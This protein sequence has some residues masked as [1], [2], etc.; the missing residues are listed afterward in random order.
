MKITKVKLN[1]KT[2]V[3][4]RDNNEGYLLQGEQAIKQQQITALIVQKRAN[5]EASI[6][7]KTLVRET[8]FKNK[9]K[10]DEKT[11]QH[12][13]QKKANLKIL[14]QLFEHTLNP[15]KVNAPDNL[16]LLKKLS[17]KDL[18][19]YLAHKFSED[20]PLLY[21]QKKQS[22]NLLN[23]LYTCLQ[24]DKKQITSY[25]DWAN[26]FIG[27][28]Q[29]FLSKSIINNT[30]KT[31]NTAT[32][33][34]RLQVLDKL[35]EQMV[36]NHRLE[37]APLY[38]E[39][40]PV[41]KQWRICLDTT[42]KYTQQDIDNLTLKDKYKSV[43]YPK[44]FFEFKRALKNVLTV[45]Q[46]QLYKAGKFA[47]LLLEQYSLELTKYL[48][49]YF[50]LKKSARQLTLEDINYYLTAETI[51]QTIAQQLQNAAM[52]HLLQRGKLISYQLDQKPQIT[53]QDLQRIKIEEAF[54]MQFISA[55]AFAASN[56][57]NVIDPSVKDDI[58]TQTEFIKTLAQ[59]LVDPKQKNEGIHRL[60]Q[61]L[62]SQTFNFD[63]QSIDTNHQAIIKKLQDK[64]QY[65]SAV[66]TIR[67]AI[68]AIRNQVI[69]FRHNALKQLFSMER[70][71][72]I[73][74]NQAGK[75]TATNDS[76]FSQVELLVDLFKNELTNLNYIFTEKIRTSGILDFYETTEIIKHF[77][78]ISLNPKPLAFVPGF[79][80]VFNWG[81][82][83]QTEQKDYLKLTHYFQRAYSQSAKN[84]VFDKKDQAQYNLLGLIYDYKFTQTFLDDH[85]A[86]KQAVAEVLAA[87]KQRAEEKLSKA[88]KQ[89]QGFKAIAPY[90]VWQTPEDYLKELQSEL[91]NDENKKREE[92]KL[93]ADQTGHYQQFI[94]QLFVKGFDNFLNTHSEL[95]FYKTP[96]YQFDDITKQQSAKEQH[97]QVE[98][99]KN[100]LTIIHQIDTNHNNHIA[101]WLFCKMLDANYLNQLHNQFSKWQQA[102]QA[103]AT[104]LNTDIAAFQQ[105]ISLSLL[106]SDITPAGYQS[107]YK[108]KVDYFEELQPFT[109]LNKD[110][111]TKKTDLFIQPDGETPIIYG[112]IE[113]AKKYATREV[114]TKLLEQNK[115]FKISAKDIDDWD[116]L[117]KESHPQNPAKLSNIRQQLHSAWVKAAHKT[118]YKNN[119]SD[120]QQTLGWLNSPCQHTSGLT[121]GAYYQELCNKLAE[122]NWLDNKVHLI[123]IRKLHHLLIDILARLAGFTNLLERDFQFLDQGASFYRKADNYRLTK[124]LRL[125][126]LLQTKDPKALASIF[127]NVTGK[128][129]KKIIANYTQQQQHELWTKLQNKHDFYKNW[130]LC[131]KPNSFETRNFIA[132]FNYLS[133]INDKKAKSIL[134]LLG[135]VRSAMS[136]DRKLKNAVAKSFIDLMDKHGIIITFE[137]LYK[138][139]QSFKIA[140]ITS[141]YLVHLGGAKIKTKQAGYRAI[142]TPQHHQQYITMVKALLELKG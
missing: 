81:V 125:E 39:L 135:E 71:K 96:T 72:V 108:N 31:S 42:E 90:E 130:F 17:K 56:L 111:L 13:K 60:T 1:N 51:Q 22:L 91:M 73:N 116:K 109:Q 99:L 70:F 83:Y 134:E 24:Q 43:G 123:Y 16:Y 28:K 117:L 75:L 34:K 9:K 4:Q 98:Q 74:Y 5:F 23:D 136:Y 48:A 27:N 62:F 50:P 6:I 21:N 127:D 37:V 140:T 118:D 115:L 138:H 112:A 119:R 114:L 8:T 63:T 141:K 93:A 132:H 137:P 103:I 105:I 44:D 67:S 122:Y 7:G 15:D 61:F 129:V 54:A 110:E 65:L 113:Q 94:W 87:N 68:Y 82:T 58:L 36:N 30:I 79:K 124:W 18:T 128:T 85:Q 80:K 14:K 104:T 64:D 120:K 142:T 38:S 89:K 59:V 10:D 46:R 53:S 86:F 3:M 41:I 77:N 52:Q 26:W 32:P 69:H 57:R 47:N 45:H 97:N 11:K 25:K 107:S 55:C 12:N 131:S 101:F 95:T 88:D 29:Y 121:N 66:N 102:Q 35:A 139:N 33:S 20:K 76:D 40:A 2:I 49:R 100:A 106:T 92:G 78:T 19:E 126:Y 133:K 84:I